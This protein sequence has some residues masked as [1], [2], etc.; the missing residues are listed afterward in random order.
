MT[1]KRDIHLRAETPLTFRL[2]QPVTI[3]V[4]C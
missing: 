4:K 3:D 2:V 1:G